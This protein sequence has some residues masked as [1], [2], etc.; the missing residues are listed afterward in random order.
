MVVGGRA[1]GLYQL[2][3]TPRLCPQCR[4]RLV[5]T[6]GRGEFVGHGLLGRLGV[7]CHCVTCSTKYR[8]QGRWTARWLWWVASPAAWWLWWAAADL[9]V[10]TRLTSD[11]SFL[12]PS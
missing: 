2:T 6:G 5:M 1:Q 3:P 4:V 7:A 9:Q 8:A 11:S 12:D 10:V